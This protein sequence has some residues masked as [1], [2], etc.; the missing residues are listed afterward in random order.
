MSELTYEDFKNRLTIQDLLLDAGYHLNRRDG[1]RYPSYVRLD[2]DGRRI[3]GDKFIVTGNNTCCFQ[4]PTY[5]N[6]NVIS[7]IKEHPD[8]FSDYKP[9]MSPDRLVNLVCNRLLNQPVD[10][11][12]VLMLDPVKEAKPFKIANYE[13]ARFDPEIWATQKRFYPYFVHRGIDLR[14][15]A[16]FKDHFMLAKQSGEDK[17]AFWNLSFPLK[18]PGKDDIVGF[19]ERGRLNKLS[20]SYKGKAEGSNSSQGLWIANLTGGPLEKADKVLWF[21]SAYDAMAY[22]QLH[23]K[24]GKDQNAVY[25]STGGNPTQNQLAGMLAAAPEAMHHLCFDNDSAG[26]KFAIN[27]AYTP[28][29]EW[30]QYVRS[31]TDPLIRNRGDADYL[32]KHIVGDYCEAEEAEIEYYSSR[33]S[34]LVCKED[35]EAIK[36]EALAALRKFNQKL[37]D[38]LPIRKNVVIVMSPDGYK[39]WN[40]ALLAEIERSDKLK[41]D[42]DL[43]MERRPSAF[44]R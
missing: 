18:I 20:A 30:K 19:E 28:T 31:M 7:F 43:S 5:K 42:D 6:Y 12:D 23:R 39:D 17:P 8:L 15:Q 33:S 35:L 44:H 29:P 38:A 41:V 40:E 34:G 3:R 37:E 24:D 10:L 25:V 21:E 4:P 2:S 22:H 13:L 27:Y 32:P 26:K 9:G 11:R 1:M 14:T 36:Q 16:A